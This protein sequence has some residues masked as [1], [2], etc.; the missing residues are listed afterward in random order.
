MERRKCSNKRKKT[1]IIRYL[2]APKTLKKLITKNVQINYIL[3]PSNTTWELHTV[4][5]REKT[6]IIYMLVIST[7][8]SEEADHLER[9]N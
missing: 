3:S 5:T 6:P 8:N 9:S 1:C 4:R 2:S 7:E